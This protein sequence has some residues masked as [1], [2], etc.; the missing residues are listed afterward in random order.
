MIMYSVCALLCFVVGWNN[1]PVS[2]SHSAPVPHFTMYHSEQ[3]W[4]RDMGQRYCGICELGLFDGTYTPL[5]WHLSRGEYAPTNRANQFRNCWYH[6]YKSNKT[7]CMLL[8]TLW[9]ELYHFNTRSFSISRALWKF[10]IICPSIVIKK[11]NDGGWS[12]LW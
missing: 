6:S 9:Y 3:K 4:V 1:R 12:L 10:L 5:L 7:A 11:H 2:Q 8:Y